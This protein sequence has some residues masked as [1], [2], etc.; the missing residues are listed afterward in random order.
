MHMRI[1]L[2]KNRRSIK[3]FDRGHL[4][5]FRNAV[6]CLPVVFSRGNP[7]KEDIYSIVIM[8]IM[9]IINYSVM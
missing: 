1:E 8:T 4:M 6:P 2:T 3:T 7:K 5:S 9:N